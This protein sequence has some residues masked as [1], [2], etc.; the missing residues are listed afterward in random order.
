MMKTDLWSL[1]YSTRQKKKVKLYLEGLPHGR[2]A[3]SHGPATGFV[4]AAQ[5]SQHA[6][7]AAAILQ[8]QQMPVLFHFWNVRCICLSHAPSKSEDLLPHPDMVWTCERMCWFLLLFFNV[9]LDPSNIKYNCE[10]VYK[11]SLRCQ[12]PILVSLCNQVLLRRCSASFLYR[13]WIWTS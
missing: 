10:P 12:R 9:Q 7:C 5:G 3:V 2:Y 6:A 1:V 4:I 8:S 13:L 11:N